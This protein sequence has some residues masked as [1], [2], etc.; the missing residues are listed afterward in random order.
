MNRRT[1]AGTV[2]EDMCDLTGLMYGLNGIEYG[3][4]EDIDAFECPVCEAWI[5]TD[6]LRQARRFDPEKVRN[7]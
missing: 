7:K 2:F 3:D 6:F 4:P 1:F 5:D